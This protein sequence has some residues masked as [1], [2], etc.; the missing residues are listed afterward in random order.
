ML[1][2]H[3]NLLTLAS[4][5]MSDTPYTDWLTDWNWF[6]ATIWK[7]N[8]AFYSFQHQWL[9]VNVKRKLF[10]LPYHTI[11]YHTIRCDFVSTILL[12][13]AKSYFYIINKIL[14][15]TIKKFIGIVW[16][17]VPGYFLSL[18]PCTCA[19]KSH[20]EFTYEIIE[21]DA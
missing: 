12:T 5:I 13:M 8:N 16:D 2:S 18:L 1:R 3:R 10:T 17:C 4:L 7:A 9:R 11:Q 14:I 6:R 21:C 20:S 15:C 19:T